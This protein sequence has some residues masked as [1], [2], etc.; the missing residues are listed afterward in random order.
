MRST[1]A[2]RTRQAKA[3]AK[4]GVEAL[5]TV[6]AVVGGGEVRIGGLG[7][8]D[9]SYHK[10]TARRNPNTNEVVEVLGKWVMR[11]RAATKVKAAVTSSTSSSAVR[12]GGAD[13]RRFH[14]RRTPNEAI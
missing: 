8:F 9:R 2:A 5:I 11:F 3:A 13:R 1:P 14:L 4:R 12:C 6:S 7:V 10:A